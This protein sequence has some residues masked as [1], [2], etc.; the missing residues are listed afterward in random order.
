MISPQGSLLLLIVFV[1]LFDFIKSIASQSNNEPKK[2]WVELAALPKPFATD[3]LP[4][5]SET[6]RANDS[7]L[8]CYNLVGCYEEL[9]IGSFPPQDLM[10]LKTEFRIYYKEMESVV[11]FDR[12]ENCLKSRPDECD[13]YPVDL[14]II[15]NSPFDPTRRT[16]VV[17]GGYFSKAKGTWE[18]QL[19]DIWTQLDDVNIILVGWDRANKGLYSTAA[20]NSRPVARQLTVLLYYLAKVAGNEADPQLDLNNA[21]FTENFY[22]IGHSLG[23]H[24]SGFVGADLAGRV[25]RITGLDPAGPSFDGLDRRFRLDRSDARLVDIMHTNAGSRIFSTQSRYGSALASGHIDLWA[26]DGVHQPGCSNDMLGCSHKRANK[27]Y[28]AFLTHQLSMRN[29]MKDKYSSL[30]RLQAYLSDTFDEFHNGTSLLKHCP[31]T[32]LDDEDLR[33]TDLESCAIPVDYV[34][35]FDVVRGE[36]ETKHGLNFGQRESETTSKPNNFYFYTSAYWNDQVDHYL[37]RIRVSSGAKLSPPGRLST[38]GGCDIGFEIEAVNGVYSS[39]KIKKY[40]P[41]DQ[42]DHYEI[43][44][45]FLSPNTITKYEIAKLDAGDFFVERNKVTGMEFLSPEGSKLLRESLE[46]VFPTSVLLRG[47]KNGEQDGASGGPKKQ[48]TGILHSIARFFHFTKRES[49]DEADNDENSNMNDCQL[50][51]ESFTVQ[52]LRKF[53]RHLSAFYSRDCAGVKSTADVILLTEDESS[54]RMQLFNEAMNAT[55]EPKPE[56]SI[57][58]LVRLSL[59]T[60][61]LGPLDSSLVAKR[62]EQDVLVMDEPEELDTAASATQEDLFEPMDPA[63]EPPTHQLPPPSPQNNGLAAGSLWLVLTLALLLAVLVLT[64]VAM[65]A[66]GTSNPAKTTNKRAI[67]LEATNTNHSSFSEI[68]LIR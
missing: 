68:Q 43:V 66:M 10:N 35:W 52:P 34:S 56:S 25:G 13:R 31:T 11:V 53:H 1:I 51:I 36:L 67:A 28:E 3:D 17:I 41:V 63:V 38:Q 29:Y 61:I 62:D 8:V 24:I 55:C 22:F 50:V 42:G 4:A 20:S 47:F 18:T 16:I 45:P 58:S 60:I 9:P 57:D 59:H 6:R 39:Y 15:K 49:N 27:Y 23:A 30:Y 32:S 40:R 33:W 14:S 5:D 44:F 48:K 21:A 54:P 2:V 19:R 7:A 64:L 37:I 26:N 46:K 12:Y 65:L